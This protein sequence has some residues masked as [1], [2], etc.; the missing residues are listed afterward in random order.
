MPSSFDDPVR[1]RE[2]ELAMAGMASRAVASTRRLRTR[3]P[4]VQ[5]R[6]MIRSGA[7]RLR[8]RA[9]EWGF[10]TDTLRGYREMPAFEHTEA[11]DVA[12]VQAHAF[13]PDGVTA[14][15][16]TFERKDVVIEVAN[17]APQ[18]VGAWLSDIDVGRR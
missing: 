12:S 1:A 2:A 11:F 13:G 9:A 6:S 7:T 3:Q 16:N 4:K 15:Q 5:G 14:N 10:T 17:N 8:A 18:G